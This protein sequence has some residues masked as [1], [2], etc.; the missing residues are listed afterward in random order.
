[1]GEVKGRNEKVRKS[2]RDVEKQVHIGKGRVKV[3]VSSER[4]RGKIWKEFVGTLKR[5]KSKKD[6]RKG[7][8][9]KK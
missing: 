9:R 8:T 2:D 3:K 7:K 5:G 6:K 1:M 4:A